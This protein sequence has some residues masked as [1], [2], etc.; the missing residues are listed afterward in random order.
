[1]NRKQIEFV[2]NASNFLKGGTHEAC[3]KVKDYV[4]NIQF[5]NSKSA[6]D[7]EEFIESI[8][9]LL[10]FSFESTDTIPKKYCCESD[11]RYNS[12]LLC[13]GEFSIDR[14]AENIC[15]FYKQEDK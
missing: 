12:C 9:I 10:S 6:I 7:F 2:L 13:R 1:M 11:C 3:L 4:K 5:A 14:Q 15:P 8:N